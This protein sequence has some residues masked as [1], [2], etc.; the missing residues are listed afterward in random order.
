MSHNFVMTMKL[1]LQYVDE[2]LKE[3]RGD[4]DRVIARAKEIT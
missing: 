1:F 4:K 2:N 3:L